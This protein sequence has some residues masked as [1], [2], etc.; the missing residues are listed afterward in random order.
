MQHEEGEQ[1][2]HA[3][4]P[5]IVGGP[6]CTAVVS[7]VRSGSLRKYV[8]VDMTVS[9]G[10]V[11][12][13]AS[14][15]SAYELVKLLRDTLGR[16]VVF[17]SEA[18]NPNIDFDM[19]EKEWRAEQEGSDVVID[20][21]QPGTEETLALY[22]AVGWPYDPDELMTGLGETQWLITARRNRELVGLTRALT[23]YNTI[24]YVV[25]LLVHP[26]HQ[27][28]G[29]ERCSTLWCGAAATSDSS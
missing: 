2:E 6:C 10:G 29:V 16:D 4:L 25:D 24:V 9:R 11:F 26:D 15:R 12:E 23:D 5:G 21:E 8:V 7:T 18:T 1:G 22:D 27:N 28:T 20:E 13:M 19:I 14:M 17:Y 3:G